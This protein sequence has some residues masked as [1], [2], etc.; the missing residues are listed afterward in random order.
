MQK[1]VSAKRAYSGRRY[2]PGVSHSSRPAGRYRQGTDGNAPATLG[3]FGD[4]QSWHLE[5]PPLRP[6]PRYL[7]KTES[8]ARANADRFP[9]TPSTPPGLLA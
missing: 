6:S 9:D 8:L 1:N 4:N 5:A 2:E 3:I 7:A